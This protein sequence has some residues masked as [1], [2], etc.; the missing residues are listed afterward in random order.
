MSQ[1]TLGRPD[2]YLAPQAD[3]ITTVACVVDAIA[4]GCDTAA[5]IAEGL[6]MA[7]RQGSYYPHA[8]AALGYVTQDTSTS[9]AIWSLTSAGEAFAAA[10]NDARADDLTSRLAALTELDE[11]TGTDGESTLAARFAEDGYSAQTIA[12]RVQTLQAW[13]E[14]LALTGAE[15][16][17]RLGAS[18][19]QTAT[20]APAAA[21]NLAAARRA[22][23]AVQPVTS[24][25]TCT[26]CWTTKS[27]DGTCGT[28]D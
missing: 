2:G 6:G 1:R 15:Q 3:R 13:A 28:C 24:G 22:R 20:Y 7:T 17:A 4:A 5:A 10:G 14:F 27:L 12:R 23:T 9:P 16:S 8:A 21:A 18:R 19:R 26:R 25:E 11:L